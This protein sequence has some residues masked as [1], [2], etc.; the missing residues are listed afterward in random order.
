M[1]RIS[2][3]VLRTGLAVLACGVCS[4]GCSRG[5]DVV[6][7]G[8]TLTR[9]GKPLP[10]MAVTFHPEKGRTSVAVTDANGHFD[11]VYTRDQK[12]A[13]RGKHKVHVHYAPQS[14]SYTSDNSGAPADLKDIEAKYGKLESTKLEVQIDG[15]KKDLNLAVD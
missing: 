14:T 7:V 11:L 13:L 2:A 8:G 1:F 5:P 4:W 12:G 9:N 3:H 10:N 15:P 6:E